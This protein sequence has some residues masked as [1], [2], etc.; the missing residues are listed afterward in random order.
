MARKVRPVRPHPTDPT[1]ALVEL[2]HGLWALIDAADAAEVGKF[3]W[4]VRIRS[5][6]T[7]AKRDTW[8]PVRQVVFLHREVGRLAGLALTGDVDHKDG[9]GLNCRRN[10]LRDAS[11][12]QNIHN[13]SISASNTSGIKGVSWDASRGK[14][15]AYIR[16]PGKQHQLGRFDAKEEAEAVV[17]T[18]RERLHGEFANHGAK[19]ENLQ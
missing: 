13:A 3:N 2:P 17:R 9:N 6:T 11:R 16:T 19:G 15:K 14:W 8:L 10:N 12:A 7:Y 1:L 5:H 4:G 18:A